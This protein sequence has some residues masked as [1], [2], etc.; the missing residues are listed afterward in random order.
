MR[1]IGTGPQDRTRHSIMNYGWTHR[2]SG[3]YR[4]KLLTYVVN[5]NYDVEILIPDRRLA[6]RLN[7]E[8][9][10]VRA[11]GAECA[12]KLRRRLTELRAAEALQDLAP[13]YSPPARCHE[14]TGDRKGQI[15]VDVKHP[16]RLLFVPDHDPLPERP[17]GGLDW[18]GVTRIRILE[19]E[20]T[21][22]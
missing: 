3:H 14:L 18:N 8:R 12:V 22:G 6:K 20:N 17:E 7:S 11:F 19:V 1:K 16:Y 13:P 9:E 21:H 5:E 15:S 2:R 10:M 4:I